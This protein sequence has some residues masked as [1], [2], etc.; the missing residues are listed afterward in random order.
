MSLFVL[1]QP[2]TKPASPAVD[3]A[4]STLRVL[5]DAPEGLSLSAL[6]RELDEAK[7]S[8]HAVLDTMQRHNFVVKDPQT[9][10]YKLGV[11]VLAIGS[12]YSRHTNLLHEFQTIARELAMR[13]GETVQLA[14]LQ[15]RS[16]LYLAKQ[17]GPRRLSLAAP[18][19]GQL[20][21]HAT[22]LGKVL[23]SGLDEA[24]FDGLFAGVELERFTA[25]TIGEIQALKAEVW[26]VRAAGFARDD[27]EVSHQLGCLAAPVRDE[28]GQVVAA[29]S[30]TSVLQA[31]H[32]QDEDFMQRQI[33]DAA[34]ELSR[35]LGYS[36]EPNA[37]P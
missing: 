17:E 31:S 28:A 15:G 32:D 12:A 11:Q 37:I 19:G 27:G 20:P 8:L 33:C 21:A 14:T 10:T 34:Y 24:V 26:R 9:K 35:R 16:I 30:L 1:K 7:S 2:R 25:H 4:L 5:A 22:A 6:S 29:V 18:V 13:T 23:L 36:K 3:R